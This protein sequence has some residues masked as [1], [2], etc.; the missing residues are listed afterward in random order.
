MKVTV[1]AV[2][3]FLLSAFAMGA[4]QQSP[5]VDVPNLPTEKNQFGGRPG[6]FHFVTNEQTMADATQLQEA[7]A[8]LDRL[9]S[10]IARLD[11]KVRDQYSK[12]M[13]TLRGFALAVH[14]QRSASA[15]TTASEVEQRLNEAKGTSMC[16]ACHG[17]GMM[18]GRGMGGPM[19]R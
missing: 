19:G 18:H 4:P 3:V 5:K 12:D 10:N 15:G 14:K 6:S 9:D 16:G 17:H 8:A 1:F 11:P 13:K 7:F 2:A